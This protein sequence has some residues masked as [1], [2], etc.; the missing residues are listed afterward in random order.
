[1]AVIKSDQTTR[2]G[3]IQCDTSTLGEILN[4][5]ASYKIVLM[6][7][8]SDQLITFVI[9]SEEL[10]EMIIPEGE[11]REIPLMQLRAQVD[12]LPGHPEYRKVTT[13]IKP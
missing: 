4:L 13:E 11:A 9:T 8:E 5:P 12:T 10:P 3:R 1:M 2:L 7:M 6:Y